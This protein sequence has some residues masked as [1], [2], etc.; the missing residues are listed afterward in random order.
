MAVKT[1]CAFNT[2]AT[3]SLRRVLRNNLWGCVFSIYVHIRLIGTWRGRLYLDKT[4][5]KC[6]VEVVHCSRRL[7]W[8]SLL[9]VARC[10][11]VVCFRCLFRVKSS[12]HNNLNVVAVVLTVAP[13]LYTRTLAC[14]SR[15]T[16]RNCWTSLE[17]FVLNWKLDSKNKHR[18]QA[19]A[20]VRFIDLHIGYF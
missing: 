9:K 14:S 15:Y 19:V 4:V 1:V 16:D 10:T 6:Q 11:F 18:S 20:S 5:V 2:S 7:I 3:R 12:G 13:A 17:K 8:C